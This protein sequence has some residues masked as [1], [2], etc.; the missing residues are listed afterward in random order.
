[1]N[2]SQYQKVM[3]MKIVQTKLCLLVAVFLFFC[4]APYCC[5]SSGAVKGEIIKAHNRIH[6]TGFFFL[7]KN[8]A[9]LILIFD[10]NDW[11]TLHL[12]SQGR[13]PHLQSFQ[14]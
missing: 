12:Q 10:Q 13:G 4:H 5:I 11:W 7:I 3:R 9:G 14:R 1:M 2:N 8:F 6:F